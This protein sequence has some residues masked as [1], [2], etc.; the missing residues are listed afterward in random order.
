MVFAFAKVYSQEISA[1]TTI[2]DVK[3]IVATVD[4][5]FDTKSITGVVTVTFTMLQDAEEVALDAIDMA[6][7]DHTPSFEITATEKQILFKAM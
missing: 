5:D 7:N 1:Q 4:P 2:V 3:Q 6:V